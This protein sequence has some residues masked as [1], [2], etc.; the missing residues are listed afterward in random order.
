MINKY[1]GENV[2]K[3]TMLTPKNY[4]AFFE[5]IKNKTFLKF[6]SELDV[7]IQKGQSE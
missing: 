7:E 3:F 6:N 1:L 2:Y 4:H 5:S